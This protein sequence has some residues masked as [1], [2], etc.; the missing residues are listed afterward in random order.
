MM[1]Q[2]T[3]IQPDGSRQS[4]DAGEDP[5]VMHVAVRH[6]VKRL[7]ADCGGQLACA[8]CM[9]DVAPAWIDRVGGPGPDEGDMI[10]DA[11]GERPAGRRLS[12]QITMTDALDGLEVR[13]PA[14]QG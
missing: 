7:P 1:P 4:F 13:L 10:E 12:C 2:V 14:K 5:T 6:D 9:V 3:F 11:L 8:T